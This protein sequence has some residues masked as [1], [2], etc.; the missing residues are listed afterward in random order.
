[1]PTGSI[2][3]GSVIRP[4]LSTH[5]TNAVTNAMHFAVVSSSLN[6]G[7]DSATTMNG[8]MYCRTVDSDR[9]ILSIASK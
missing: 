9:E 4:V 2:D 3:P 5:P 1:M 6:S 8:E 7:T